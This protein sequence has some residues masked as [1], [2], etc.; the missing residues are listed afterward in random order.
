MKKLMLLLLMPLVLVNAM[1]QPQIEQTDNLLQVDVGNGV[2]LEF[3]LHEGWL[4]GLRSAAAYGR[5]LTSAETVQ[6]PLIAQEYI[7]PGIWPFMRFVSAAVEDGA[8]RIEVELFGGTA[9][10][11]F[12]EEFVFA[13]DAALAMGEQITPELV[14]LREKAAAARGLLDPLVEEHESL[15]RIKRQ[16]QNQREQ[17]EGIDPAMTWDVINHERRMERFERQL[18]QA[19]RGL[20]DAAVETAEQRQALDVLEAF[21]RAGREHIN[22]TLSIFRD[23]YAFAHLRQPSETCRVS[24]LIERIARHADSLTRGGKITIVIRPDSRNIAGWVWDGWAQHYEVELANGHQVNNLRQLGTWEIGGKVPGL[25]LVALRY[26]GLGGAEETIAAADDGESALRAWS[27]TEIMAGAAG[28]A[29]AV[30]PVIPPPVDTTLEDRGYALQHRLGAWISKMAR[31]AGA[32]FVDFQARDDLVLISSFENQGAH[33]AVTEIFPGDRHVSQIDEQWFANTAE[34]VTQPQLYLAL[35]H[36]AGRNEMTTRWQETDQYFR[37]L[38]SANLGFQQVEPLPGVGW[39]DESSRPSR[40]AGLAA[41]GVESMIEQGMRMKVTHT[42]GWYTE[43]H[44]NGPDKPSTP[45]GN[46]NRVFDWVITDDVKEGWRGMTEV[47]KKHNVPYFIYLGGMVR[48][49]GPFAHMVGPEP[50]NWGMNVPGAGYSHGYPPLAGHNLY[51]EAT[52]KGLTS[53]LV[54]VQ[55]QLGMQGLWCD[56]F[57]NMFMSQLHW[58]DGS[59]APMQAAWWPLLAEWSQRGIHLMAESHAF[60]GLSCS[61]ELPGWEDSYHYFQYVWKW[62]RGTSQNRYKPE[63]LDEM[64]YRFMANK[65][66]VAPDWRTEV[67]PSFSRYSAEYMAALPLMRRSWVLPD[68]AGVLWLPYDSNN[69][70]VLFSFIDRT[71]PEGVELKGIIDGE[72]AAAPVARQTYLVSGGNLPA[73]FGMAAAP[74]EDP[75]MQREYAPVTWRFP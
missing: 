23:Y 61:I 7:K 21:E 66:W 6:R 69:K 60:P 55:E 20:Y 67:I 41:G 70:G 52:R 57:Q 72:T 16:L 40:Y 18:E 75:R 22:N 43:Q 34:F 28:S 71:A 37:D 13:P 9:Q 32:P 39:L 10:E 47:L 30:S 35:R 49:D 27:T 3:A 51:I 42:P 53:R 26:R 62:L 5:A 19:K 15:S 48:P 1:A 29:A 50:E 17:G 74:A 12:M 63:Q 25:T 14:A 4:L 58:G 24:A 45:G 54:A 44:R 73:A 56:S 64:A 59:G 11:L 31:G 2:K 33:R 65:S 46:S 38:V 8:V 36:S 68:G